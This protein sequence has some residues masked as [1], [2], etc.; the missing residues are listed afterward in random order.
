MNVSY[1]QWLGFTI[2]VIVVLIMV[3]FQILGWFSIMDN[4]FE[5]WKWVAGIMLGLGAGLIGLTGKIENVTRVSKPPNNVNID[6]NFFHL[7]VHFPQIRSKPDIPSEERPRFVT[8]NRK[9]QAYRI[10]DWLEHYVQEHKISWRPH[11]NERAMRRFFDEENITINKQDIRPESIGLRQSHSA[12][13]MADSKYSELLSKLEGK[14]LENLLLIYLVRRVYIRPP[15]QRYLLVDFS[16]QQVWLAP[17]FYYEL[18]DKGIVDSENKGMRPWESCEG[19]C[20]HRY[21][22]YTF[23]DRRYPDS[24]L[25][26]RS[27]I[28]K[29]K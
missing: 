20:K 27:T 24:K 15:V 5:V 8:D 2:I 9:K 18:T 7:T 12:L 28:V 26:E 11:D 19:W 6:P 4:V 17:A 13:V 22:G 14:K 3:I 23:N 25:L 1:K 10:P 21:K 29:A 16:E